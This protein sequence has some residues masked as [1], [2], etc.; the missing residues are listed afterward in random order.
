ML[1]MSFD[2]YMNY[3]GPLN[4]YL[5]QLPLYKRITE[6]DVEIL[7]RELRPPQVLKLLNDQNSHKVLLPEFVNEQIDSINLWATRGSTDSGWHYDSY[8]NFL[9][10]MQGLK[11]VW[12]AYPTNRTHWD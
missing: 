11:V 8:D 7:D 2:D 5:A 10:V 12:L 4:L 3:Q 1:T 9:V 6:K